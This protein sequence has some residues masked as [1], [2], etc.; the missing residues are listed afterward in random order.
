MDLCRYLCG[1]EYKSIFAQNIDGDANRENVGI[2]IKFE[3]GSI[4]TISYVAQ[5]D[6]AYPKER[7]EMFC[8]NSIA[9]IDDFRHLEFVRRG[10][11]TKEKSHQNKGHDEQ[12]RL[13]LE[14]LQV[15]S[16]IPVSFGESVGAT[17]AT[18]MI[19]E[20]LNS[21][22]AQVFNEYHRQIIK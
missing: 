5:G 21:G 4:A 20:S 10:K 15:S 1:S 9:V 3:D 22:K 8:Q 13:W 14:S 17:L 6:V 18:F 11:V 16:P 19:H 12:L 7:I 2:L